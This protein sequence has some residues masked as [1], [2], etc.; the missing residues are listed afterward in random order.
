MYC[1]IEKDVQLAE[2]GV[3]RM[4][5]AQRKLTQRKLTW[6]EPAKTGLV[7]WKL[8]REQRGQASIE[9]ALV[10]PVVC[11]LLALLVQPICVFYTRSVMQDAAQQACRILA[12]KGSVT[13]FDEVSA[14]VMRRLNAIPN[15]SLFR[16]S[17]EDAI[18]V[19]F[20]GTDAL[21]AAVEIKVA[22]TP[23]PL[24]GAIVQ[25][26]C[27]SDQGCVVNVCAQ[28]QV[29]PS[30]IEGDYHDWIQAWK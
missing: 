5:L 10:L 3:A 21:Q 18:Q 13:S 20:D 30:W 29:R 26:F 24:L 7:W 22:L 1:C 25:P 14:Y 17:E 19:S 2:V 27:N 4:G 28:Q 6:K 12:T 23:L 15:V 9:A 11:F 8:A 16:N